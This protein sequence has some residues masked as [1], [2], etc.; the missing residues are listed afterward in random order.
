[1]LYNFLACFV[2]LQIVYTFIDLRESTTWGGVWIAMDNF[3]TLMLT[4]FILL[5][6]IKFQRLRHAF[7]YY[8]LVALLAVATDSLPNHFFSIEFRNPLDLSCVTHKLF[9]SLM[10]LPM[11]N[12]MSGITDWMH[13][14]VALAVIVTSL[15]PLS[16]GIQFMGASLMALLMVEVARKGVSVISRTI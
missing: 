4:M 3:I 9:F 6:L 16:I 11:G 13:R 2:I 12:F 5:R 7:W 14:P 8:C 15:L 10:M 1:M